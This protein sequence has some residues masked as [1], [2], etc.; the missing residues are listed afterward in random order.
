MCK[1]TGAGPAF[2]TRCV[3]LKE[4]ILLPGLFQVRNSPETDDSYT[5]QPTKL[6][7]LPPSCSLCTALPY[8][9]LQNAVLTP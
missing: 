9:V 6:F 2:S 7:G 4:S 5:L 1:S 8:H 3:P